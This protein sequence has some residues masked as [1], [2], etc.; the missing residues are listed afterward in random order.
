MCSTSP[1]TRPVTVLDVIY[2][3][4][5]EIESSRQDFY[6]HKN[7]F[8]PKLRQSILE[9]AGFADVRVCVMPPIHEARALAF[10]TASAAA[11]RES[12]RMPV[13]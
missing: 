10:K 12:S 3:L 4:G 6:A 9:R 8:T 11:P 7:G 2:G 1:F 5:K 13:P